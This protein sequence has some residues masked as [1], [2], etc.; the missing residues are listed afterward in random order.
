MIK[1]III[2]TALVLGCVV[3]AQQG[4]T[5]SP[6][7]FYGIGLQQFRGT[8]ENRAIGG[9]SLYSDSLHLNVVNPAQLGKLRFVSF[10][11]GGNHTA[12][13]L[14][15]TGNESNTTDTTFDYFALGFPV[16]KRGGVSFGLMPWS[17]VGYDIDDSNDEVINTFEGAGGVN[18]VFLSS[19]FEV[20]KGL[21]LGATAAYYFGNIQNEAIRTL[22]QVELSTLE[23]NRTDFSGLA[24][25]FGAQYEIMISENLQLHSSIQYNTASEIVAEN[26]RAISS[27]VLD[28]SGGF[29]ELDTVDD[30]IQDTNFSLPSSVTLGLGIGKPNKWFVGGEYKKS[31]T[32]N[33]FNNSFRTGNLR[34]V[35]SSSFKGGGLYIPNYSSVTSYFERVTY[36]A[37][38]RYEELGLRVS[39]EDI[40]EFGISFGVGL[41]TKRDISNLN[42][43]FEYG[44]RGTTDANLVQ[45]N[46]FNIGVSL[47]LNDVWFLKSKFN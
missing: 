31:E 4:G 23:E 21:Y 7:S 3:Q 25:E 14:K 34:F 17:T 15:E 43:T 37:G 32:S 41:P 30:I 11:V 42:I 10:T 1:K 24:W 16:S 33:F 40:N 47:S 6:Y 36:R 35:D 13:T 18:R 27:V 8:V 45:E 5:S 29:T 9:L 22:D 44:Q 26:T 28:G 2:L 20:S 39:N 38:V 46:F 19:G 12:T